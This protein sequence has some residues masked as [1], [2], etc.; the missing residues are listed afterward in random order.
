MLGALRSLKNPKTKKP[1]EI[2]FFEK[3]EIPPAE[4]SLSRVEIPIIAATTLS[5][6]NRR[7]RER[8]KKRERREE[9]R[10]EE[11]EKREESGK[12]W[13]ET[14]PPTKENESSNE[15]G[16]GRRKPLTTN[17]TTNEKTKKDF[18]SIG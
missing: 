4:I 18:A 16:I 17:E 15:L 8:E 14:L 2:F 10:E 11:E 9:K 5:I 3:R 12:P 1:K 6:Q 7:E 13:P